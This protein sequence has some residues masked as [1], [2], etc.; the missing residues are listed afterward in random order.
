MGL[1]KQL[2]GLHIGNGFHMPVPVH[3]PSGKEEGPC[4][5]GRSSESDVWLTPP[6][7]GSAAHYADRIDGAAQ[8]SHPFWSNQSFSPHHT[9]ARTHTKCPTIGRHQ[10]WMATSDPRTVGVELRWPSAVFKSQVAARFS[11]ANS[12][13]PTL[14]T[15]QRSCGPAIR[16]FFSRGGG[17][18]GYR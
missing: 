4:R 1:I 8:E 14:I 10:W 18:G 17:G 11:L 12:N 5:S 6:P 3:G 2:S 13:I 7:T 9:H 16:S 15:S